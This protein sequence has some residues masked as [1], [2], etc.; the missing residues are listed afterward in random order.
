MRRAPVGAALFVAVVALYGL[1][2]SVTPTSDSPTWVL[3]VDQPD[4]DYLLLAAHPLPLWVVYV[5]KHA[6]AALG[7]PV[8][9]LTIL[10][11]LGAL[12]A[13]AGAVFFYQ[14]VRELS[15]D[16]SLAAAAGLL[17]AASFGYW[18]FANGEIHHAGLAVVLGLFLAV[19]RRRARRGPEPAYAFAVGLGLLNA[20]AIFFHQDSVLFGFAI[21]AMLLVG[22]PWRP[23]LKEAAAYVAAGGAGTA[24]LA[25]LVGVL[26]RGLGSAREVWHWYFW[27]T[28]A[29]GTQVYDVGGV[30]GSVLR[31][32]K[33]QLTAVTFGTQ[34]AWDVVRDPGI[35]AEPLT[36]ALLALTAVTA[37]LTGAL[38]WRGWRARAAVRARLLVPLTGCV[39]WVAAWKLFLNSWFQPASTEYHIATVPPLLL[40]ALLGAIAAAGARGRG[41]VVALL[42]VVLV[43]NLVG[44]IL[45]WRR[46][47]LAKQ[48]L[49][50]RFARELSA[51]DLFVSSESGIDSVFIGRGRHFGVKDLFKT[52]AKAEGFAILDV[53]IAAGL[54]R[55]G[56]VFVYNVVPNPFTLRRIN[57]EGAR[58]GAPPMAVA[59]FEAFVETLRARYALVPVVTYW[60]ESKIPLFLYGRRFETIW[61]VRPRG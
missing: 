53:T 35:L 24:V 21:V 15:G 49:A 17:L 56:R 34:V 22:R 57:L 30:S 42:A 25:A 28:W 41:L 48:A 47:G 54:R 43:V 52:T 39:V 50:T 9:T 38:A 23:G 26:L 11:A 18:Y 14:A 33:A 45:P 51:G 7:T 61:E 27:P 55:P 20:V 36:V 5:V 10:Q 4:R 60:E 8:A 59:D 1:T 2:F 3:S 16:V 29:M 6:L 40:L 37:A 32:L 19:L 31:S 12:C 44:A 58:R 13:A 46:Y